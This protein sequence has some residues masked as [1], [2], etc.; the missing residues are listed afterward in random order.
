MRGKK[1]GELMNLRLLTHPIARGNQGDLK[2]KGQLVATK[3]NYRMSK[4][5]G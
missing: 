1:F 5:R 2:K 3:M 4:E